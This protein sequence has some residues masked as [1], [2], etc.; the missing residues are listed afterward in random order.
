MRHSLVTHQVLSH[1]RHTLHA[2]L[3]CAPIT[4]GALLVASV[5]CSSGDDEKKP[6]TGPGS[7][8]AD[9]RM[10]GYDTM[11]TFWNRGETRITRDTARG[12]VKAWEFDTTSGVSATPVVSGG[13]VYVVTGL[14][15]VIALDLATGSELYRN[16]D[17]SGNPS[18]TLDGGILYV[19]ANNGTIYALSPDDLHVIWSFPT[20]DQANL[21]GFSSPVVTKD[22][23]I[24]GGSTLEELLIP[25]GG[26]QFRGFITAVRKDGTFGWKIYT[27]EP[28]AH[29][30]TLWST[31]SVDEESG[32]VV[33]STSNNHGPP[34][35]DTSDA[36]LAVPLQDGASFLWKSQI[37]QGDV[38]NVQNFG[39]PDNDF[40]ANPILFE[41]DGRKVAAG[42]NKG[43]DIWVVDRL[44]G[45]VLRQRNIGGR[46]AATGGVFVNG[47][48]DGTSLLVAC[49]NTTST[50]P[51][52]ETSG[53]AATL[54]SINP[55]TLDINW[56]R[57]VTGLV[58]SWITVA[59]GAGFF[60]KDKT[61]QA[62]D[63]ATG[64]VLFEFPTEGTISTAPA[65]SNGYV[66]FGSGM[67]WPSAGATP[68][69]KYYALK[70]P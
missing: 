44:T 31:V 11:S 5:G 70:V 4:A 50:G 39:S 33:G 23:V 60:A 61:L 46:G 48:W 55:S 58:F 67:S 51:G 35:T 54:F 62:F 14:Q 12:L 69:T 15:G 40:G 66:V 24:V 47:A 68:G 10:L 8:A 65:I 20:D 26:P 25:S 52:S 42:A 21:V 41:L 7:P 64:E 6:G 37:F 2:V 57:Q 22:F 53:P 29:G 32:I 27:V 63:T 49:N 19:H 45:E 28:G 18:P 34:A 56:E 36:F 59:N 13:K 9:W 1:L 3:H 17:I 43:G 30:A 38:W 16:P